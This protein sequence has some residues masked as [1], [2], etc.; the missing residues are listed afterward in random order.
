MIINEKEEQAMHLCIDTIRDAAFK[1]I[2]Q[3]KMDGRG[4]FV[5][6][7]FNAA[8][9]VGTA[10]MSKAKF[11]HGCS[12]AYDDAQEQLKAALKRAKDRH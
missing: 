10:G 6:L 4:V 1:L 7:V 12:Q 8:L 11:L 9:L 2:E 3:D 5:G